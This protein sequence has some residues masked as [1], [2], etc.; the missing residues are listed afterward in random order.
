MWRT[1]SSLFPKQEIKDQD[2]KYIQNP[3]RDKTCGPTRINIVRSAARL[4]QGPASARPFNTTTKWWKSHNELTIM[5]KINNSTAPPA[6]WYNHQDNAVQIPTTVIWY[7]HKMPTRT[8]GK[9]Q[10]ICFKNCRKS[11]QLTEIT[12]FV[13]CSYRLRTATTD[14]LLPEVPSEEK[15]SEKSKYV[16]LMANNPWKKSKSTLTHP[17][18]NLSCALVQIQHRTTRYVHA[19]MDP[20]K[21]CGCWD[22]MW[23]GKSKQMIQKTALIHLNS[24]NSQPFLN[25]CTELGPH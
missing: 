1:V 14:I 22:E 16:N 7:Y 8:A 23:N 2:G 15:R 24:P 6:V 19:G 12:L 17:I 25:A 11:L 10:E 4:E 20:C 5:N 18:L 21:D 13:A 3:T 9:W